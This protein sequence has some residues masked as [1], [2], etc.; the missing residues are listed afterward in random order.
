MEDITANFD[1]NRGWEARDEEIKKLQ[2]EI[3]NLRVLAANALLMA[4]QGDYS[5]CGDEE[6]VMLDVRAMAN[7][8]AEAAALGLEI[9][10]TF[11]ANEQRYRPQL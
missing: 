4:R 9:E 8:D 7:L 3:Q 11:Y 10:P 5:R 2:T 6:G 1:F